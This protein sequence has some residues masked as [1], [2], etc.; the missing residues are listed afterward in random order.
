MYKKLFEDDKIMDLNHLDQNHN[1][2][3]NKIYNFIATLNNINERKSR[4]GK[5]FCFFTLSDD[6]SNTDVI[7]FSEV[8]DNLSFHLKD[9]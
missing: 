5:K 8:L 4:N 1:P 2:E 7:C 3:K 6:S 9:W